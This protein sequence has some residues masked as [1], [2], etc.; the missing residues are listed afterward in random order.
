MLKANRNT[1]LK[2]LLSQTL[3]WPEIAFPN[4]F[5]ILNFD[6]E[7]NTALGLLLSQ[8]PFVVRGC[9]PQ[10]VSKWE[11]LNMNLIAALEVLLTRTHFTVR[12]SIPQHISLRKVTTT[13]AILRWRRFWLRCI[14]WSE[15]ASP[16]ALQL[17]NWRVI[18][19]LHW[20]FRISECMWWSEMKFSNAPLHDNVSTSILKA[21]AKADQI[22]R[23]DKIVIPSLMYTRHEETENH[24]SRSSVALRFPVTRKKC[25]ASPRRR[26]CKKKP[27][28]PRLKKESRRE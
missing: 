11:R 15:I 24:L 18:H 3:P 27:S 21:V 6:C 16:N 23:W 20:N 19:N 26:E 17:T 8:S 25:Q 5:H 7:R 2:L 10:R 9:I 14:S 28:L 1:A 4:T 22:L 12:G 13:S